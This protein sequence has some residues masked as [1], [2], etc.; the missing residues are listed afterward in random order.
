VKARFGLKIAVRCNFNQ[1]LLLA[2]LRLKLNHRFPSAFGLKAGPFGVYVCYEG[3]SGTDLG[4]PF[5]SEFDPKRTLPTTPCRR[6]P[7]VFIIKNLG[8]FSIEAGLIV[9][10]PNVMY[11]FG[12]LVCLPILKGVAVSRKFVQRYA[13]AT[14]LQNE[15]DG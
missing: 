11:A 12:S 5:P 13:E 8:R 7:L 14:G 6:F 3:H 4:T 9:I 2:L 15:I 1:C 10:G